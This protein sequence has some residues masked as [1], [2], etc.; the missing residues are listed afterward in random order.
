MSNYHAYVN[1]CECVTIAGSAFH[2]KVFMIF[3]RGHTSGD[4]YHATWLYLETSTYWKL[5]NQEAMATVYLDM[6][7]L[8]QTGTLTQVTVDWGRL[9]VAHTYDL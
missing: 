1:I 9:T 8:E 5:P 7:S 6:Q 2:K 3:T 4:G